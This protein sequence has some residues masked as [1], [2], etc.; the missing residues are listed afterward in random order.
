MSLKYASPVSVQA[1]PPKAIMIKCTR[2]TIFPE[3]GDVIYEFQA[4]NSE[5]VKVGD[6]HETRNLGADIQPDD[7]LGRGN[8][9][10][11]ITAADVYAALKAHGYALVQARIGVGTVE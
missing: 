1:N 5:G 11:A 6:L 2:V 7:G 8:G 4:F 3:S 9:G 10:K